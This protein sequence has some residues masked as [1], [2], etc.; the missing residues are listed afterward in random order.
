VDV[1]A[2]S[3][4]DAAELAEVALVADAE[5]LADEDV[6]AELPLDAE[7]CSVHPNAGGSSHASVI[8]PWQS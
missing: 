1:V 3:E 2:V 8:W 7:P 6:A 4:L 5:E